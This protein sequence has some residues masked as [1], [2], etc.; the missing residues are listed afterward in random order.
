MSH[1]IASLQGELNLIPFYFVSVPVF[2][3]ITI[4]AARR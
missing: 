3:E 1:S 4:N 2:L